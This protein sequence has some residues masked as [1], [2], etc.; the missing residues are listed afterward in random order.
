MVSSSLS[1][2]FREDAYLYMSD[3]THTTCIPW[4]WGRHYS[5]LEIESGLAADSCGFT[6][7][8]MSDCGTHWFFIVHRL[9]LPQ[10]T[11]GGVCALLHEKSCKRS[12]NCLILWMCGCVVVALNCDIG[13]R[14][15][16]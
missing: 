12:N 10:G 14:A 5:K 1:R 8:E 11:H 7:I 3:P 15:H 4:S 2:H 16:A 9:G 6:D 13:C